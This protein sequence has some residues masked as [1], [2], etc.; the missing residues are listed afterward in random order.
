MLQSIHRQV[1]SYTDNS[2]C[3]ADSGDECGS[4]DL[5]CGREQARSYAGASHLRDRAVEQLA[6]LCDQSL[7][8]SLGR[9]DLCVICLRYGG[10]ERLSL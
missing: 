5:W 3:V 6:C 1:V 2:D 9:M 8:A 10:L 7:L 4:Q